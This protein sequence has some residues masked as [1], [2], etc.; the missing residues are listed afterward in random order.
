MSALYHPE[1]IYD[2][3][4]EWGSCTKDGFVLLYTRDLSNWVN[5]ME[6]TKLSDL[7]E[8]LE[9]GTKLHISVAFLSNCG[10][11]KTHCTHSQSVHDRPVCMAVKKD[12]RGLVSCYRCRN[13]VQ[14]AVVRY[15][16]PIAGLCANGVYEYCRPVIYDD[17][18]VCVIFIGNVLT[19]D[20]VQRKRLLSKVNPELMDTMETNR[21]PEDCSKIADVLESYIHFLITTYGMGTKGFDPL[22]ENIKGFLR[23]NM[24]Y[25]FSMDELAAAFNYTPKYL[26]H[27]FRLRT[28]QT[29]KNYSNRLRISRAKQLLTETDMPIESIALQVG[30][31]SVNYFDRVFRKVT[32]LAPQSYRSAGKKA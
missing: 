20:P 31:N 11:H 5:F 30:F 6:H 8:T 7:I 12:S 9:Y 32:G 18:A 16:K 21:T 27:M 15:R 2:R 3:I 14:K 23:E 22:V 26:G 10:N 29:I 17:R 28:G 25:D 19:D 13:I 24:A 4:K 1:N